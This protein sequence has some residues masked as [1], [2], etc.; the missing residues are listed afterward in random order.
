MKEMSDST[1]SG[2]FGVDVFTPV[3]KAACVDVMVAQKGVEHTE[4]L[5]SDLDAFL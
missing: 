3:S 5:D 4:A 2:V 1:V